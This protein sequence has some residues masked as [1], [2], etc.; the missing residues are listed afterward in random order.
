MMGTISRKMAERQI[1]KADEARDR[2]VQTLFTERGDL[3]AQMRRLT[4]EWINHLGSAD[5]YD[6]IYAK[7]EPLQE[8]VT[9]ID[10]RLVDLGIRFYP[11]QKA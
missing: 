3:Q 7:Q 4:N 1:R 6:E 11:T 9:Q 2:E 10:A 5:I 8:R